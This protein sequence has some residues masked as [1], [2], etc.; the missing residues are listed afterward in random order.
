M[1]FTMQSINDFPSQTL[2]YLL[3]PVWLNGGRPISLPLPPLYAQKKH[4]HMTP[5]LWTIWNLF[6]ETDS[7]LTVMCSSLIRTKFFATQCILHSQT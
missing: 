4:S 6:C 3:P 2:E 5:A 1:H 7:K